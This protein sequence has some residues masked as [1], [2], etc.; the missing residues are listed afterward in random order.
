MTEGLK[1][2]D[3][4]QAYLGELGQRTYDVVYNTVAH[5]SKSLLVGGTVTQVV[6]MMGPRQ[7]PIFNTGARLALNYAVSTLISAGNTLMQKAV[8]SAGLMPATLPGEPGDQITG[9]YVGDSL[10]TFGYDIE[11][12]VVDSR[13]EPN[14]VIEHARDVR[15]KTLKDIYNVS[16]KGNIYTALRGMTPN[17]TLTNKSG[18]LLDL[19]PSTQAWSDVQLDGNLIPIARLDW[20]LKTGFTFDQHLNNG[21]AFDAEMSTELMVSK[22]KYEKHNSDCYMFVPVYDV[23]KRPD[24]STYKV[25]NVEKTKDMAVKFTPKTVSLKGGSFG[26]TPM[27]NPKA[28]TPTDATAALRIHYDE[29]TGQF[30]AAHDLEYLYEKGVDNNWYKVSYNNMGQ[31][32]GREMVTDNELT[33][34]LQTYGHDGKVVQLDEL[35]LMKGSKNTISF[36][37]DADHQYVPLVNSGS[38]TDTVLGGISNF[39]GMDISDLKAQIADKISRSGYS[40]LPEPYR[41]HAFE[42]AYSNL[43]KGTNEQR[44]TIGNIIR[45]TFSLH[46]SVNIAAPSRYNPSV[47]DTGAPQLRDDYNTYNSWVRQHLNADG[48]EGTTISILPKALALVP[49]TSFISPKGRY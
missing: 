12:G 41:A 35:P 13:M 4:Q 36:A 16:N 33:R 42:R 48:N 44:V 40:I 5:I 20:S 18:L 19:G 22:E 31:R 32:L 39:H 38:T 9:T 30:S 14:A 34:Y 46:P 45:N 29:K 24:G 28:I 27:L 26:G 21:D 49:N 3:I 37:K 25:L 43:V 8:F 47:G 23:Y 17:G 2:P 1:N 15:A 11:P 7:G 10:M 6:G